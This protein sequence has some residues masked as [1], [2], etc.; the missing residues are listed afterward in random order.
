MHVL[1]GV[2][3]HAPDDDVL[4]VVVP[5]ENRAR[6]DAESPPDLGGH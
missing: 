1:R 6:T 3:T 4:T 2:P 5:L